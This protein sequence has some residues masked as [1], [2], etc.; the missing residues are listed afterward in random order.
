MYC[1]TYLKVIF[2]GLLIIGVFQLPVNG[3]FQVKTTDTDFSITLFDGSYGDYDDDGHIDDLQCFLRIAT[4]SDTARNNIA[5]GITLTLPNGDV[6]YYTIYV[7][8]I[9]DYVV[10]KLLFIN[11][12]YVPGDYCISAQANLFGGGILYSQH[13]IIFDPPTEQIPDDDPFLTVAPA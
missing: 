13:E 3:G 1:K 7:T 12:A 4:N 11:H 2:V 6:Y 10:L 8:T 5:V 9:Y